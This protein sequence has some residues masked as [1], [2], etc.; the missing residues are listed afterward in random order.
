MRLFHKKRLN[1]HFL[2]RL[3]DVCG[4]IFVKN[5]LK[6]GALEID[7]STTALPLLTVVC[8]IWYNFC[9]VVL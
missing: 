7:F 3:D 2:Q 8:P 4:K 9:P 1:Q 6:N 5:N